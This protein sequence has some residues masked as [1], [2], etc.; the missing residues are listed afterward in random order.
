MSFQTPITVSQ[1]IENIERDRYLLPGIQ[2][3]FVWSHEQV[4]RL[5]DSLLLGY[6]IS[7]FLFWRVEGEV[8]GQHDFYRFLRTYRQKYKTHN[9]EVD[10]RN[11][12]DFQAVLDGQQRLTALYIGLRGSYAYKRPRVWDADNEYA[13]PTRKLYLDLQEPTEIEED[14]RQYNFRFL[15]PSAAE[16]TPDRWFEVSRIMA[17]ADDFE[18][19]QFLEASGI[20]K[21]RFGWQALAKLKRAIHSAPIINYY[22]ETDPSLDKALNIFI[23]INS[24][25]E[26]L[27]YSDLV[28]SVAV[29]AWKKKKAREEIHGLVDEILN[30]GFQINKDIILRLFLLLHSEDVRFKP[31]NFTKDIAYQVEDAWD[32]IHRAFLE[33]FRL[34]KFLGFNNNTL[35]SK[36]AILPIVYYVV[37]KGNCK[38]LVEAK[39]EATNRQ[40]IA[41]WLHV[42]LLNQTMA[43]Q[44]DRTLKALRDAMKEHCQ[45]DFPVALTLTALEQINRKP[46]ADDDFLE[47]LL[48]TRKDD[49]MAFSILSLL[50][51]SLGNEEWKFEKDHLHPKTCFAEDNLRAAGVPDDELEFCKDEAHFDSLPNLHLLAEREN[52]SKQGLPFKEWITRRTKETGLSESELRLRSLIPTNI[53]LDLKDFKGFFTARKSE[54][55]IKLIQSLEMG[56]FQGT[57]Q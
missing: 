32:E 9:E 7:S 8:K 24:G 41:R 30:L 43:T 1:A 49:S 40:L 46:E 57:A 51:P 16:T 5:F 19:D 45:A 53:S 35:T 23:R 13:Y 47:H 36:N 4:E 56:T 55:K 12:N 27:S 15:P 17:L 52:R 22:L 14:G 50:S 11:L 20:K 34:L 28:M 21:N 38:H 10:A 6:P 29:S 54:L 25:G 26:P 37:R 31:K 33:V 42:L 48:S 39:A 18:F 44:S 3:E 2:R